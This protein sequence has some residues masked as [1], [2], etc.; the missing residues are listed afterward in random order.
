MIRWIKESM[1]KVY[2]MNGAQIS[3]IP[4]NA[5]FK[6]NKENFCYWLCD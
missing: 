1:K 4:L 2:N 5:Y 6:P 3:L